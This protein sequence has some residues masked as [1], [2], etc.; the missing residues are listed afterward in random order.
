MRRLL[1]KRYE[2]VVSFASMTLRGKPRSKAQEAFL[3]CLHRPHHPANGGSAS[4]GATAHT[5]AERE[6]NAGLS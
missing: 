3:A 4:N 5:V 2:A 1:P 6:T